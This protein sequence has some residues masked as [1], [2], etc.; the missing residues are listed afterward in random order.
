MTASSETTEVLAPAE[1]LLAALA[2]PAMWWPDVV[3]REHQIEALDEL[4]VRLR[5]GA[6]RTWVDAPTGSG[7]TITFCALAAALDGSALIL[8]PRRNLAEQGI[9]DLDAIMEPGIAA[10][11]SVQARGV[12][13]ASAAL[14]LWQEFRAARS[15]LLALIPPPEEA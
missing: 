11:L 1:R 15:G 4:A 13:P 3:L 9:A 8:V 5:A 12:S 2:D 7:K 10:L 6:S 14:A